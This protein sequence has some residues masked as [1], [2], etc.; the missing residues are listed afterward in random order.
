MEYLTGAKK[1]YTK[2][3]QNKKLKYPTN[4]DA[5]RHDKRGQ[6]ISLFIDFGLKRECSFS[7]Y[8]PNNEKKKTGKIFKEKNN[9]KLDTIN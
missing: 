3:K 7:E 1:I 2:T 5:C 8:Q 9:S 4:D 6:K